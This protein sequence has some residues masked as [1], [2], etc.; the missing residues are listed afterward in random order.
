MSMRA[1]TKRQ[2]AVRAGIGLVVLLVLMQ[3]VPYG[4]SHANPPVTRSPHWDSPQTARLVA[5]ACNDCHSNLTKWRWYSNIAPG[6]WLIQ[7]DVDGGR[8]NLN[9]SRWD[10]PQPSVDEVIEQIRGGGMPPI[11][12]KLIHADARLS[13][14]EREQ[15]VRGLEATYSAD[16]PANAP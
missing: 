4:H 8:N 7:N 10:Q 2:I 3:F 6:S 11:Q 16:P 5:G 12:Y 9:F 15:L 1:M 13:K 14:S